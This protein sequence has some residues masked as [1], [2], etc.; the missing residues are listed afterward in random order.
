MGRRVELAGLL[1]DDLL[2]RFAGFIDRGLGSMSDEI[3]PVS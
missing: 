1:E 3:R 2:A